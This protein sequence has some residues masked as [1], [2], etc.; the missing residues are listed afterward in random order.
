MYRKTLA[1]IFLVVLALFVG[2]AVFSKSPALLGRYL[3]AQIGFQASTPPNQFN[4]LAQQLKNKELTLAEKEKVLTQQEALLKARSEEEAKTRKYL[5][6]GGGMLLA[7]ILLNF[8]MD[9]RKRRAVQKVKVHKEAV[10]GEGE[11]V[12]R[13]Y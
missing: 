1:I 3:L 7:L 6:L 12:F 10:A 11:K 2:Q 13:I 5:F 9:W 8:C 4:T